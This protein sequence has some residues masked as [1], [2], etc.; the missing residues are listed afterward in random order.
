LRTCHG[1]RLVK[2]FRREGDYDCL[3]A[4][5]GGEWRWGFDIHSLLV[6]WPW[7]KHVYDGVLGTGMWECWVCCKA[8]CML[9]FSFCLRHLVYLAYELF[10]CITNSMIPLSKFVVILLNEVVV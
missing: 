4:L 8:L 6:L 9:G 5:L 7:E 2:V 1:Y 10:M 3:G